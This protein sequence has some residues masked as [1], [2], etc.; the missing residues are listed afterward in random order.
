M[1]EGLCIR[2]LGVQHHKETWA[3]RGGVTLSG[4]G[5]L[6]NRE[7]SVFT[8]LLAVPESNKPA[9]RT[10]SKKVNRLPC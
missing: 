7:F 10:A 5:C 6:S 8:S 1:H 4:A 2:D 3:Q 9:V